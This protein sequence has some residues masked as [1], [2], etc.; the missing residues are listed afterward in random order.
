[1]KKYWSQIANETVWKYYELDLDK[2]ES[3]EDC[4]KILKFLCSIT[5]KP[6]PNNIEYGGFDEVREYFK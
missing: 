2:V 6:M 5:M 3:V 1:M 4:K